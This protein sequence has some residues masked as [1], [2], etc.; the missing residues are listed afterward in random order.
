MR[1]V[2][3]TKEKEAFAEKIQVMTKEYQDCATNALKNFKKISVTSLQMSME[4]T[5]INA[6]RKVVQR[7][8]LESEKSIRRDLS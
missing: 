1:L 8:R 3:Q 2:I 5:F 4:I 7:Y 6:E